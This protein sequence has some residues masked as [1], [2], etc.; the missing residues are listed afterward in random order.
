MPN[1]ILR[2]TVQPEPMYKNDK[3][4][5]THSLLSSWEY[6]FKKEGGY[7]EFLKTLRKEPFAPSVAML[8]GRQYENMVSSYRAGNPLDE[9]HK[10]YK[11][12]VES[13][14]LLK[15]TVEQVKLSENMTI[16]GINFVLYGIVD[17]MGAGAL[18][19]TKFSHTYSFGKYR[20]STQHRAYFRL[21]PEAR[22]FTYII[23]DG[24]D[25]YTETYFP[26]NCGPIENEIKSF[27]KW[28]KENNLLQTYKEFWKSKY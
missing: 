1:L 11:G 25:V 14:E 6:G 4:L 18:W 26:R 8:D 20:T 10:W 23:Y 13:A 2:M 12:I 28:L 16:D 7:E 15:G 9:G 5:I 3:Y 22:Q 24:K 17:N 21:I 27:L 19:D